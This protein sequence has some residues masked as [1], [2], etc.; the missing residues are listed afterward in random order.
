MK[1]NMLY[2]N[3]RIYT[4]MGLQKCNG[5]TLWNDESIPNMH[6]DRLII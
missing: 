6:Y 2:K 3:N 4:D 1:Y 5:N